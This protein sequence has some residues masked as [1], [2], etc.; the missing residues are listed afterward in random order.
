VARLFSIFLMT[1]TKAPKLLKAKRKVSTGKKLVPDFTEEL[2]GYMI[3]HHLSLATF[4]GKPMFILPLSVKQENELGA[5]VLIDSIK[6]LYLQF[7]RVEGYPETSTSGILKSRSNLKRSNKPLVLFFG[8]RKKGEKQ[9]ELQHNLL[10]KLRT[11]LKLKAAG[12]TMAAGDAMYVAPLFWKKAEYS[13][14]I[15]ES[16]FFPALYSRLGIFPVSRHHFPLKYDYKTLQIREKDNNSLKDVK[17]DFSSLSVFEGHIC[18]PPHSRVD[19]HKH[20]YSFLQTGKEVCFHSPSVVEEAVNL[21]QYLDE[22]TRAQDGL[23]SAGGLDR[24]AATILVQ[25]LNQLAFPQVE[26]AS[27]PSAISA[28]G[29]PS[30]RTES[31]ILLDSWADFGER[32][33]NEYRISQFLLIEYRQ[34]P[35]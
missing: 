5:D 12:N 35:E 31:Q 14:Y 22:F 32:L 7:K 33:Y 3:Q 6:P 17:V 11:D 29:P 15:H 8:L 9:D 20:K 27:L 34:R 10:L 2:A 13:R 26:Q 24:Q 4:S 28:E 19:T 21:G 25:R 1:T 23:R 18:I 16:Y 30:N